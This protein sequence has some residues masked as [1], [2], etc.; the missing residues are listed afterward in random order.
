MTESTPILGQVAE[1][2]PITEMTTADAALASLQRNGIHTIFGLPGLHNDPFFDSCARADKPLRVISPRHEQ[3]CTYMALGA[4][5]STGRPQVSVVVPGP[6]FLNTAAASLTAEGMCAPVI[7][8]AG[9]IPQ[10]D[11][12]RKH[13]HLHEIYDQ[14]GIAAHFSKF[15]TRIRTPQEAPLAIDMAITAALSQRPGPVFVECAMDVWDRK[16][17]VELRPPSPGAITHPLNEANVAAA[18]RLIGDALNPMIVVGGGAM[19]A[20]A[21][22][23]ELAELLNAP[24]LS[25]RRGRGV[26]PTDHPL[27]IN[28][29]IGH[30]LWPTVDVVI[31]IGT[32][33]FIQ[34]KQW[35]LDS[36]IKVVR[37]DADPEV[38]E[39]FKSPAV[40]LTGDAA[41]YT[42]ALVNA[43][44]RSDRDLHRRDNELQLHRRWFEERMQ[45]LEPQVSFLRAIRN[46]LP[47]DGIFVDEVT[48]VGFAS[49]LSFP[50]YSPRTFLSPGYQDNLGWGYGTALGAQAV[51]PDRA[52]VAIAGDGGIMYQIGELATA[53]LHKLPVVAIVFDNGMFGNVKRIQRERFGSRFIAA[54]LASPDFVKLADAFGIASFRASTAPQLEKALSEALSL[55]VPGLIHVPGAE[56]PSIW[57]MLIMPRVRG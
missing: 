23:V 41:V 53:A 10:A 21:E 37:I 9:Q 8:I 48:Q 4:A 19:D 35:G 16:A 29:P 22:I 15:T 57:D 12:D 25:Y 55:R 34:E 28:L 14:I 30:R 38:A 52:V 33:L 36:N 7:T 49:R 31:A 17:P 40:A 27:A 18:S 46:A 43:L 26:I 1:T 11:I 45:R 51:N 56:M 3:A 13:G 39:R 5:L 47:K 20:A 2:A 24:V 32:R 50:V 6:G 44:H 42:R 54:E